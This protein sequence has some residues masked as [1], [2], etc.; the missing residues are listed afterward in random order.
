M[1]LPASVVSGQPFA[2]LALDS[3]AS[4]ALAADVRDVHARTDIRAGWLDATG[5]AELCVVGLG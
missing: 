1:A 2:L 5:F 3:G 4:V